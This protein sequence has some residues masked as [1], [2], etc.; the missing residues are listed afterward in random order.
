MKNTKTQKMTVHHVLILISLATMAGAAMGMIAN[1]AGL[2]FGPISEDMNIGR[3]TAGMTITVANLLF[4]LGGIVFSNVLKGNRVKIYIIPGAVLF[5]GGT[6]LLALAP[7]IYVMFLLNGIRGFGA[8]F[9]GSVLITVIINQWFYKSNGLFTGMT[10]ASSGITGAVA[11]LILGKVIQHSSWR[12]A[13]AVSAIMIL[14][15]YLPA[16]LIPMTLKPDG[17]KYRPYGAPIRDDAEGNTNTADD[18]AVQPAVTAS[19]GKKIAAAL[20]IPVLIYATI[21]SVSGAYPQHFPGMAESISVHLGVLMTSIVLIANSVGKLTLG[22]IADHIGVKKTLLLFLALMFG[23]TLILLF[24]PYYGF[25]VFAAAPFGVVYALAT[26][27]ISLLT[28][29]IFGIENYTRVYPKVTFYSGIAFA[30]NVSLIGY[31]YDFTGSY[32]LALS[33]LLVILVIA[34]ASVIYVYKKKKQLN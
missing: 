4:P 30:L 5:A 13:Y 12:T 22:L 3:G 23:A 34:A 6:A 20:F 33:V 8:G 17:K 24:L 21:T 11:S 32:T 16:I 19:S 25:Y 18:A 28:K 14:A 29:D 1:T 15:L 10:M 31:S 7:N 9:A 26:V 27:G 2:F